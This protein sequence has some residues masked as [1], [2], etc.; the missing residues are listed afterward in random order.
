MYG[1]FLLL[2]KLCKI[3]EKESNEDV[4]V[5]QNDIYMNSLQ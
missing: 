5:A 1:C 4:T 2:L 3:A